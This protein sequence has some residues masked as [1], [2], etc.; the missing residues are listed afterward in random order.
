M[1]TTC[2]HHLN[3]SLVCRLTIAAIVFSTTILQAGTETTDSK[4][5]PAPEVAAP[6]PSPW[7]VRIGIP[8]WI[9]SISGD[10]GV[11]NV[12][13]NLD[14]NPLDHLSQLDGIFVLSLD[15][16]YK[17]W[18][19]FGDGFYLK[20]G[21]SATLPG[22]LF[23]QADITLETAFVTAFLGYRVIDCE[24]GYLTL[25]AGAR[26]NYMSGDLH[27]F[28]NGDPRFPGLRDRLGIPTS[29]RFSGSTSW[30]DPVV[31]LKGKVHIWKPISL[32][33]GGDV[34]GF[35]AASGASYAIHGGVEFQITHWLWS[36]VGWAYQKNDY[37]VDGFTNKTELSGPFVQ[38]GV[39]F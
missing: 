26:Y 21:D 22:L 2:V 25:Y 6:T 19:I 8:G 31:G 18:E 4:S 27:V 30:V 17:R 5:P 28:D 29:L 1:T 24:R 32:W 23:S 14:I 20:V 11:R 12:T 36:Q 3:Q 15:V 39:N 37:N 10:F 7:E 33:A 38:F 13:S 16:R 35:G 9:P 34:A